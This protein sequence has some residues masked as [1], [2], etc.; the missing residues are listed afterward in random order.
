MGK[1]ARQAAVADCLC[2]AGW[3]A[4]GA[5]EADILLLPTP[6]RPQEVDLRGLLKQAKPGAVF[7]AGHVGTEAYALAGAAG[8]T[9][10]DY[11]LREELAVCNAVA[12]A[13]G[14]IALILENSGRTIWRSRALVIGYGRVGRTLAQRLALL[15]AQVSV[16]ARKP[17]ARVW[18]NSEGSES[19]S[20]DELL[21]RCGGF[22]LIVNTVPDMVMPEAVLQQAE[23]DVFIVDLASAPGGVDHEAAKKL[24]LHELFAP[25]LPAK[26]T[27]VSAG[28][29]IAQTVLEIVKERG[30]AL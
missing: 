24:G 30:I 16:A 13:E 27:P 21:S 15:G 28:G 18:A 9:L 12:T 3:R 1:D 2:R 25:G 26:Y 8:H 20:T 17:Q 7:F 19:F 14:T 10:I 6:L 11:L 23:K 22:S 29:Y 5:G 4:A